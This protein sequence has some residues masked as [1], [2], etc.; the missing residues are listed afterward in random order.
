MVKTLQAL[1]RPLACPELASRFRVS[2]SRVL[3]LS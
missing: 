1:M 3:S 2:R